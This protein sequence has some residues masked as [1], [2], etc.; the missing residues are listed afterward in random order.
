MMRTSPLPLAIALTFGLSGCLLGDV[1]MRSFDNCAEYGAFMKRGNLLGGFNLAAS[2]VDLD[3]NDILIADLDASG[4]RTSAGPDFDPGDGDGGFGAASHTDT[5]VQHTGVDEADLVKTDGTYMYA[6][7]GGKLVV[8]MAWPIETAM[9][10]AAIPVDG[11]AVGLYLRDDT[12]VVIST[13]EPGD[14]PDPISEFDA[15]DGVTGWRDAP[16]TAVTVFDVTDKRAIELVRETYTTGALRE[17][18]IV[19]H[20]LYVVTTE[21]VGDKAE[22][23][24]GADPDIFDTAALRWLSLKFDNVA[25]ADGDWETSSDPACDCSDIWANGNSESTI[26]NV[27]MLDLDQPKSDFIGS[28]I[29]GPAGVV[30][31]SPDSLYLAS[32]AAPDPSVFDEFE[33]GSLRTDIHKFDLTKK[34]P[35]YEASTNI[36]GVIPDRFGLSEHEGVLRVA[37]MDTEMMTSGVTTLE[38]TE[39]QFVK[40][41]H[42]GG[43]A[44]GETMT[45]ARFIGDLGYLVTYIERKDPLFTLNLKDPTDIEV[46][47]ELEISGWSDYLHP[48]KEPGKLFAVGTDFTFWGDPV[49][50]ASIFDVSNPSNPRLHDRYQFDA[51]ISEASLDHHAFTYD[52]NTGF[53]TIPSQRGSKTVL[54]VV[55]ATA[56]KGI[57]YKGHLKQPNYGGADVKDCRQIRR[58][59]HMD[60]KVWAYSPA[61]L[62]A[63]ALGSPEDVLQTVEFTNVDPCFGWVDPDDDRQIEVP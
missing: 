49:L 13:L 18:R 32:T 3:M 59:I 42:V 11:T 51:D 20:R 17:S 23:G 10:V 15:F 8:S 38:T 33:S 40:L 63:A 24:D 6:I 47:G 29:V 22:P 21:D 50:T 4:N 34:K 30:Y 56:D 1:E 48:M 12:V 58:S 19:D 36:T 46:G 45:A 16:A 27:M 28:G 44:P 54:E 43:L 62:T 39:G 53:V 14:R 7:S 2:G 57:K 37:T 60:G 31:A 61:G 52:P 25:T 35:A 26:T 5:N 9:Q 41:D 55:K